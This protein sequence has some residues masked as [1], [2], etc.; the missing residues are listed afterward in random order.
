MARLWPGTA[1][2]DQA[3]SQVRGLGVEYV[4]V[5]IETIEPLT[6]SQCEFVPSGA[7]AHACFLLGTPTKSRGLI[8]V[9][10]LSQVKITPKSQ[11]WRTLLL[12][13]PYPRH[14]ILRLDFLISL[15]TGSAGPAG[16]SPAAHSPAPV[17]SSPP[18]SP[19]L[20]LYRQHHHVLCL[21]TLH[22]D[23]PTPS[24]FP[25]STHRT[26][27]LDV[28][29]GL[30]TGLARWP[31]SRRP[32]P[33][34][35]WL[36]SFLA[37]AAAELSP[38]LP[39]TSTASPPDAAAAAAVKERHLAAGLNIADTL[40]QLAYCLAL[41]GMLPSAG[42]RGMLYLVVTSLIPELTPSQAVSILHAMA[43]WMVPLRAQKAAEMQPPPAAAAA[44]ARG[45]PSGAFSGSDYPAPLVDALAALA[46]G[47]EALKDLSP[48]QALV[49]PQ[50]LA[51]VGWPADKQLVMA[52]LVM[53]TQYIQV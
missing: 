22:T 1:R 15:L 21:L 16:P 23:A 31:Q 51:A 10:G 42:W 20:S 43:M 30:L 49:L 52:N 26:L 27:R 18:H 11:R 8:V 25:P 41:L 46:G 5:A 47:P 50:A 37:A 33:S 53:V 45:V 38:Y 19:T 6:R 34:Q 4:Q 39:V 29:V 13:H 44:A 40:T 12:P 48:A 32:L 14:I 9:C 28:L 3:R 7:A 36:E 24:V 2:E 35:P 17:P